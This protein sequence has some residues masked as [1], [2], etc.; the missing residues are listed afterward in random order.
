VAKLKRKA[1]KEAPSL[2][3]TSAEN[4]QLELYTIKQQ[5]KQLEAREKELAGLLAPF[6]EQH[7]KPSPKGH[8][9]FSTVD[10]KGNKI[11]LQRQARRK[12]TLN[13][14]RAK[15]FLKKNGLWEEAVEVKEK[16]ADEITQDQ[17][18]EVMKNN[19]FGDFIDEEE[20]INEEWLEQLVTSGKIEMKDFETLCDINTTYAMTYIDDSKL[21]KEDGADA[22][23]TEGESLRD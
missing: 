20:V 11:H 22:I 15:A 16:L 5:K 7:F 19:G 17:I 12:V 14:E 8:F 9:L 23:T 21:Q 3:K 1:K 13:E 4:Y 6:M 2:N 18:I 10:S